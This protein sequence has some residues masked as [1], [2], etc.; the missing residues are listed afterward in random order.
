MTDLFMAAAPK[1]YYKIPWVL[2]GVSTYCPEIRVAHVVTPDRLHVEN[3]AGLEVRT[4]T[5]DEVLQIP[6]DIFPYRPNWIYQQFLKLFQNVTGDEYLVVDADTILASPLDLHQG[7]KVV[8]NLGLDQPEG[9]YHEF[10]RRFLGIARPYPHSLIS[11]CTVYRRTWVWEMLRF[12]KAYTVDRFAAWTASELSVTCCPAESELYGAFLC[13]AHPDEIVFK[14][15]RVNL[16]GRYNGE[17]AWNENEVQKL[18]EEHNG[19]VD[20]ISIHSWDGAIG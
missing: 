5:D 7:N 13:V 19:D 12:M 9:A 16:N 14:Q 8:F 1:D 3:L 18:I 11:E 10:N 20:V 2:H 15:L 17:G 6:R 4:Y